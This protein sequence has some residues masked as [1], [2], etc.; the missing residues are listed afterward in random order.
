MVVPK[1]H[2]LYFL[3]DLMPLTL[4]H[5]VFIS[6][7]VKWDFDTSSAYLPGLFQVGRRRSC[8]CPGS[9][10]LLSGSCCYHTVCKIKPQSLE[11]QAMSVQL[12][13]L[14]DPALMLF[15]SLVYITTS[16]VR[17]KDGW[18]SFRAGCGQTREPPS[19]HNP[20]SGT[21]SLQMFGDQQ[22]P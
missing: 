17:E 21:S 6:P 9:V 3:R 11:V 10:G 4:T 7:A 1:W 8:E 2:H 13:A 20:R 14:L 18:K 15:R 22:F 5:R 12:V 19:N 16:R